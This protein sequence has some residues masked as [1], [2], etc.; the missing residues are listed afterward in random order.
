M[1]TK[2][3][4]IERLETTSKGKKSIK[5]T[6]LSKVGFTLAGGFA[7]AAM[8]AGGK[9]PQPEET[10]VAEEEIPQEVQEQ[11]ETT[12]QQQTLQNEDAGNITEPQPMDNNHGVGNTDGDSAEETVDPRDVA[13][14]IAQE[15]DPDD[16]DSDNVIS[17]DGYDYAYLPDGTQQQVFVGHTPDG[18]QYILADL[19]GDGMYGDVFDIEGNYVADTNGVSLSDLAEMIDDTG[20]YMP[21]IEEAW[22][23]IGESLGPDEEITET[24]TVSE[25]D[26]DEDLLAQLTE[27][28]TDD[29]TSRLV[30]LEEETDDYDND[31]DADSDGD[32]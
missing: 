21:G 1:E 18:T 7:G 20:G 32:E 16:I 6:L 11:L 30:E 27:N 8:S 28:E 5:R 24:E 12:Q 26:L 3:F 4:K 17:V 15:I 14:S 23:N 19:D 9:R 29:E 10:P 31:V 13:Q 2:K 22:E 25:E